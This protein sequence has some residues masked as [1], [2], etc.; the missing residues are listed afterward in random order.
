M[1]NLGQVVPS[2]IRHGLKTEL[3]LGLA[4]SETSLNVGLTCRVEKMRA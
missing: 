4:N 3:N 2:G 1:P